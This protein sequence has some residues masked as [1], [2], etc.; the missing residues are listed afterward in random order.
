MDTSNLKNNLKIFLF[1][2]L[3][4]G[5][6]NTDDKEYVLTNQL[7]IISIVSSTEAELVNSKLILK[8]NNANIDIGSLIIYSKSNNTID[9]EVSLKK[10]DT[11]Y[12]TDTIVISIKDKKITLS[13][14]ERKGV[15]SSGRPFFLSYKI[16]GEKFI[17]RNGV[18]ILPK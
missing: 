5:C 2:I 8:R 1:C 4:I 7:P 14:I 15:I 10:T 11:V 9:V 3:F 18:Y 6:K 12:K 16:N 17:D 13:E